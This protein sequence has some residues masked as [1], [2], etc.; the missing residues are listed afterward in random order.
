MIAGATVG[1]DLV[2]DVAD[3]AD[4]NVLR[5]RLRDRPVEMPIDAGLVARA[6]IH[7]IIGEPRYRR[8]FEAF[9]FVVV[10]VA[11]AAVDGAMADADRGQIMNAARADRDVSGSVGGP[12][13]DAAAPAQLHQ[14]RDVAH[15]RE[16]IGF[17]DSAVDA[18]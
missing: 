3:D 2:V 5:Y 16:D 8:K 11:A 6:Q 12:I 1:A 14:R 17:A 10:G 4:V 18:D 9:L 7:E 15:A 13:V